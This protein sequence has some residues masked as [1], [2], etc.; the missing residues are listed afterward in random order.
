MDKM[1][2]LREFL[3]TDPRFSLFKQFLT[4]STLGLALPNFKT[5][6]PEGSPVDVIGTL[7]HEFFTTNVPDAPPTGISIEKN[8]NIRARINAG[9]SIIIENKGKWEETRNFFITATAKA[10]ISITEEESG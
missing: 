7:S 9:A 1:F 4:T 10:R 5:D 3:S 2:S 6:Y 8:G